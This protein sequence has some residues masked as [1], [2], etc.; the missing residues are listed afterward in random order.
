MDKTENSKWIPSEM[1]RKIACK[2]MSEG[3]GKRHFEQVKDA[4]QEEERGPET[5]FMTNAR[6]A[7]PEIGTA[8]H[9]FALPAQGA[10]SASPHGTI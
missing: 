6:P 5:V 9:H 2:D 1:L 7:Q 4:V 3:Q 8:K 10:N